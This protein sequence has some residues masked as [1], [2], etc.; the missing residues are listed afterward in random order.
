MSAKRQRAKSKIWMCVCLHCAS[1]TCM[2][3]TMCVK[4]SIFIVRF[5][6]AHPSWANL[7][8]ENEILTLRIHI[9]ATCRMF[10]IERQSDLSF[11]QR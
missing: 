11:V 7:D 9:A 3:F 4:L 8:S 5:Q 6:F 1:C 2:L 10:K